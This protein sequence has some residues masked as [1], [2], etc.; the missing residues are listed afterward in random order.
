MKHSKNAVVPELFKQELFNAPFSLSCP[1]SL[2]CSTVVYYKIRT[3]CL[4]PSYLIK[5]SHHAF[6]L[7]LEQRTSTF[8]QRLYR[9]R[10]VCKHHPLSAFALSTREKLT[11]IGVVTIWNKHG[12][13]F[14]SV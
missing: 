4:V 13:V 1:L 12:T 2:T 7:N 8:L 10:E 6:L 9:A 11:G 3:I 14:K 5:L